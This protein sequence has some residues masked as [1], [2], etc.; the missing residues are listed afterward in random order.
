MNVFSVRSSLVVEGASL[1]S[2]GVQD[3]SL[4]FG[5]GSRQGEV[6]LLPLS[7]VTGECTRTSPAR[8]RTPTNQ[9][10]L[11]SYS[12]PTEIPPVLTRLTAVRGMQV[13]RGRRGARP[14]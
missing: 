5:Q 2:S 3:L 10:E 11:Q 12:H 7:G 9:R 13:E 8:K 1:V 14:G 6:P 4:S